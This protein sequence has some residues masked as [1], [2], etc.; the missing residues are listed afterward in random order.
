MPAASSSD[1]ARLRRRG[2]VSFFRP[3]EAAAKGIAEPALRN[4]VRRGVVERVGRGLYRIVSNDVGERPV[5]EWW[6]S[7]QGCGKWVNVYQSQSFADW[8]GFIPV[9][10]PWGIN[11][12]LSGIGNGVA[13]IGG[14]G[15]WSDVVGSAGGQ[16]GAADGAEN[17]EVDYPH[18]DAKSYMMEAGNYL[19]E[20]VQKGIIR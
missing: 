8:F 18:I 20:L 4:L 1:R 9:V 11:N 2:L 19:G 7:A 6:V 13:A 17:Y 3:R 15:D 5:S 12:T 14:G 10:G 16:L